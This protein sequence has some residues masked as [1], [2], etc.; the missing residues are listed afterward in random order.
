MNKLRKLIKDAQLDTVACYEEENDKANM[1]VRNE[2]AQEIKQLFMDIVGDD[3][4]NTA[5]EMTNDYLYGRD[6]L[7]GLLRRQ[8][9]RL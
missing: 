3:E 1:T 9:R 7:R 8:I 4:V 2:L 5:L 6:E